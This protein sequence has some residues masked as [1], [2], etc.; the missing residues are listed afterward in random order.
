MAL[1][2]SVKSSSM[3]LKKEIY[4]LPMGGVSRIQYWPT[5]GP[6]GPCNRRVSI[7]SGEASSPGVGRPAQHTSRSIYLGP[8]YPLGYVA[9]WRTR[10]T[11]QASIGWTELQRVICISRTTLLYIDN[12]DNI[13]LRA[14]W[15]DINQGCCI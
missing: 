8:T 13:P 11:R 1:Y 4:L 12:F 10:G 9:Q 3:I 2:S 5:V 6:R 7:S 15:P 14:I